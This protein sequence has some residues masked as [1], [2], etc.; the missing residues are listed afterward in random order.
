MP[1]FRFHRGSLKES[2]KTTVVVKDLNDIVKALFSSMS[3]HFFLGRTWSGRFEII[4][5][6]DD[7]TNFDARIG[8]Y[9]HLV[10]CNIYHKDQMTPIGFLSEPF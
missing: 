4:P 10:S 6:P 5:Y 7:E 8:W 2:L 9:T 3:E 1:L